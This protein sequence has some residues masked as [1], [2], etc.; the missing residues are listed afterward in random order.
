MQN[1]AK[2]NYPG[3]VAFYDNRPENEAGLLYNA[4]EPTRSLELN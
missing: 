1:T 3:S 2:Q 4:P